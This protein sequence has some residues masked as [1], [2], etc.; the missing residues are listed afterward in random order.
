MTV[1]RLTPIWI[2]YFLFFILLVCLRPNNIPFWY[3][4]CLQL[5]MLLYSFLLLRG[6]KDIIHLWPSIFFYQFISISLMVWVNIEAYGD[7]LGFN[8]VDADLYRNI[9]MEFEDKSYNH[10]FYEMSNDFSI[11]DFGFPLLVVTLRKIFGP[12][13]MVSLIFF[14]SLVISL[15]AKWLYRITIRFASFQTSR[16]IAFIWGIFPF[17]IFTA[18]AGLKENFFSFCIIGSFYFFYKLRERKSL[19]DIIAFLFFSFSLLLFRIP[20][21]FGLCFGYLSFIFYKNNFVR[22]YYVPI[23]LLVF[24]ILVLLFKSIASDIMSMRGYEYDALSAGVAAKTEEN[25]GLIA[26]FTNLIAGIIGPFPNIISKDPFKLTYIT[27]Y[28]FTAFLKLFISYYFLVA[29]AQIIRQ[30]FYQLI[31]ILFFVL[32]NILMIEFTFYSLHDRYHWPHLPV[33]L[34]LVAFG[35][36]N[37]KRDSKFII[38]KELYIALVV[39]IILFF[40]LR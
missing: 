35:Y 26:S 14:N 17:A 3:D 9:S 25:G 31:P 22:K 18:A 39:L 19:F 38:K 4:V 21:F 34:I 37:Y 28:S 40:N 6:I 27:R 1:K 7:E 5:F 12:F 32:I 8:P 15:G 13:Y 30:K 33:Y 2:G 10:F 23:T 20:L 36:N 24:A 11:D 29:L 16:I